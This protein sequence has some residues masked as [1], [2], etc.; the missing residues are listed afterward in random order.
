MITFA[1]V[2]ARSFSLAITGDEL[3]EKMWN[4]RTLSGGNRLKSWF[5][6]KWEV[7]S[8]RRR[9]VRLSLGRHLSSFVRN[10]SASEFEAFSGAIEFT[11]RL[12]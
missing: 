3:A 10:D 4:F 9:Q 1:D 6:P 7:S 11:L 2:V 5:G 8:E 12:F